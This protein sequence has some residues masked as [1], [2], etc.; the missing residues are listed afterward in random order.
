MFDLGIEEQIQLTTLRWIDSFFKICP[1]DILPFVPRLLSQVLPALSSD[2]E[3]VRHAANRV[4]TSLREYILSMSEEVPPPE[5]A[6]SNLVEECDHEIN[7]AYFDINPN[8]GA[9][10]SQRPT[11]Q[12]MY[13]REPSP[14]QSADLD[15]EAAVSALTLQFLNEHET[16][17]IAALSW[18]IMLHKRARGKVSTSSPA[19]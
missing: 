17:R 12:S 10:D 6:P 11:T 16:T 18:L 13:N 9:A 1:E 4:N 14:R 15:Y 19:P 3:N 8:P 5:E 2:M 7:V